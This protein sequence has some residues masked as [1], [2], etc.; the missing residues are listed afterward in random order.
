MNAPSPFTAM[1][2]DC[3]LAQNRKGFLRKQEYLH[4]ER[5]HKKGLSI[6]GDSCKAVS[7]FLCIFHS[8]AVIH[9]FSYRAIQKCTGKGRNKWRFSCKISFELDFIWNSGNLWIIHVEIISCNKMSNRNQT[10]QD[11]EIPSPAKLASSPRPH[12]IFS[13]YFSPQ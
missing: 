5:T 13:L 9:S 11:C 6:S 10:E 8:M 4:R 7:C 3:F 12:S 1:S 2:K